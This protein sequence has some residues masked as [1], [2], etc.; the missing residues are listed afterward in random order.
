MGNELDF[1]KLKCKRCKQ[2]IKFMHIENT[3]WSCSNFCNK[4]SWCSKS[5]VASILILISIIAVGIILLEFS[6]RK[7]AAYF[8]LLILESVLGILLMLF[9]ANFIQRN[10]RYKEIIL[11]RAF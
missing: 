10:F 6:H 5:L 8:V 11:I 3:H 9:L 2:Q 7:G 4:S 1:A